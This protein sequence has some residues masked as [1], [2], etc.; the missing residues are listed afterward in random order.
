MRHQR[1]RLLTPK[2]VEEDLGWKPSYAAEVYEVYEFVTSRG[3]V[4]RCCYGRYGRVIYDPHHLD[5]LIRRYL[6]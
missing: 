1:T 6:V 3:E 5:E 2:E 4:L